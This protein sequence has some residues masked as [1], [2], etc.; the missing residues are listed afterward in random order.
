MFAIA[1]ALHTLHTLSILYK[2]RTYKQITNIV[3]FDFSTVLYY[4]IC[5]FTKHPRPIAS[6]HRYFLALNY[7]LWQ[8]TGPPLSPTTRFENI[9]KLRTLVY[10][11]YLINTLL[12][13]RT[14]MYSVGVRPC[15]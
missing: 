13:R 11:F 1:F 8:H 10:S 6:M 3:Y 7:Q 5:F 4:S 2:L 9:N 14:S 12:A 15:C